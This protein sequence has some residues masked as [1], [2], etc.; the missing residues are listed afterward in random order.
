L[1]PNI[2]K[3]NTSSNY[4]FLIMTDPRVVAVISDDEEDEKQQQQ[5]GGHGGGGR[6]R[7]RCGGT[8]LAPLMAGAW[9]STAL[10]MAPSTRDLSVVFLPS[11]SI[12]GPGN[13]QICV[14][15]FKCSTHICTVHMGSGFNTFQNQ[16]FFSPF[17]LRF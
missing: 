13:A 11:H 6:G 9:R 4:R 2:E 7:R 5:E 3:K 16:L 1:D 8:R 17:L 15:S 12:T 10:M 14:R